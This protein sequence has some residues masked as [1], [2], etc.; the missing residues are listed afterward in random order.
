LAP[1]IMV[2]AKIA[3]STGNDADIIVNFGSTLDWYQMCLQ[4]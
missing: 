1:P 4:G 2:L 3:E